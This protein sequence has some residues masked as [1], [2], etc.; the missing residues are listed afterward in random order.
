MPGLYGLQIPS[1]ARFWG[2]TFVCLQFS[3]ARPQ[4]LELHGI[5]Y[6]PHDPFAI[7]LTNW[8]PETCHAHITSALRRDMPASMQPLLEKWITQKDRG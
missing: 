5:E 3:G 1:E 2:Y 6:D 7:G 8:R 4:Y